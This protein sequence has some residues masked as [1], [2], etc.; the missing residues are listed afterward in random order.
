ML[1]NWLPEGGGG[2]LP[3]GRGPAQPPPPTQI[4][5]NRGLIFGPRSGPRSNLSGRPN[6][7][8]NRAVEAKNRPF[9][10]VD[11]WPGP[12]RWAPRTRS[13]KIVPEPRPFPLSRPRG[14]RPQALEEPIFGSSKNINFSRVRK[15]TPRTGAE[16]GKIP[17]FPKP[18]SSRKGQISGGQKSIFRFLARPRLPSGKLFPPETRAV[19][20]SFSPLPCPK[21]PTC[22]GRGRPVLK[23]P[24]FPPSS[25]CARVGHILTL[26]SKAGTPRR[27]VPATKIGLFTD[28]GLTTCSF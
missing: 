28:F 2:H 5:E 15:I 26:K 9:K 23:N 22:P 20:T 13:W 10:K 17:G 1:P 27:G 19:E 18:N 16:P 6:S 14:R 11:F 21:F 25:K 8:K 3:T 7:I 12:S 4:L 24:L